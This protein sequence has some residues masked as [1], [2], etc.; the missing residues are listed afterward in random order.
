MAA[1]LLFK[2]GGKLFYCQRLATVRAVALSNPEGCEADTMANLVRPLRCTLSVP[3]KPSTCQSGATNQGSP[4][5]KQQ[6][7]HSRGS[8]Y[9]Y[10]PRA[11]W[12]L[13]ELPGWA[14]R[15]GWLAGG[16]P[17]GPESEFDRAGCSG[18]AC[19]GAT[20]WAG[21]AGWAGL[22]WLG[23]AGLAGWGYRRCQTACRN[24]PCP[25]AAARRLWA[26]ANKS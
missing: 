11:G 25:S 22:G 17:R 15:P 21:L 3:V 4:S 24:L 19:Q 1:A 23:W 26:A 16:G 14:G 9:A 10:P 18:L 6:A 13:S 8:G 7:T 2:R 5:A 12:G 20:E